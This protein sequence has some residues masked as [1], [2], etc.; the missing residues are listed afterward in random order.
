MKIYLIPLL[1]LLMVGCQNSWYSSQR[2]ALKAD[3]TAGRLSPAEYYQ[4]VAM[5]DR[6]DAERN[7]AAFSNYNQLQ[8]V[9]A[10]QDYVAE[11]ER[12]NRNREEA[13]RMSR[14]R[15]TFAPKKKYEIQDQFGMPTGYQLEEK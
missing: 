7:Q 1:C 6:L 13:E 14:M 12:S 11:Q 2:E 5:Y 15:S 9:Q 3:Y 10:Q 8:Q 4:A